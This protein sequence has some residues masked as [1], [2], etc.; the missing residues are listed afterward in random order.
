MDF[1]LIII[2]LIS[3]I[4]VLLFPI[5]IIFVSKLH[6]KKLISIL[7]LY[8]LFKLPIVA[9][10]EILSPVYTHLF[11]EIDYVL[12]AVLLNLIEVLS[13]VIFFSLYSILLNKISFDRLRLFIPNIDLYNRNYIFLFCIAAIF[14][15]FLLTI[16]NFGLIDWLLSPRDGYQFGRSGAGFEYALFLTFSGIFIFFLVFKSIH[17]KM[18]IKFFLIFIAFFIAYLT[19]SK[20]FIYETFI[21]VGIIL[22][23][24][25]KINIRHLITATPVVLGLL[26]IN[27]FSRMD[28]IEFIAVLEYFDFYKNSATY[29]TYFFENNHSYKYGL[30]QAGGFWDIVPRALYES[31]PFFYGEGMLVKEIYPFLEAGHTPGFGGPVGEYVDFGI[32]GVVFSGLFNVTTFVYALFWRLLSFNYDD[33][34]SIQSFKADQKLAL[35]I[36]ISPGFLTFFS[37]PFNYFLFGS[38][39]L[40]FMIPFFK[41]RRKNA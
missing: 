37:F 5:S 2:F 34:S 17:S 27:L 22:Y 3:T 30:I 19:G 1:E 6:K 40:F 29:Y 14:S 23:F 32:F 13:F 15:F 12:F 20:G 4:S 7:L 21:A 28:I 26:L 18:L 41:F 39:L 10:R 24:Y 38:I 9:A 11:F 16:P 36:L 25:K 35:I 33:F 8:V 31:K